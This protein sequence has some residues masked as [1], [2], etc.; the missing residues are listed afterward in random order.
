MKVIFNSRVGVLDI[1]TNEVCFDRIK[2]KSILYA[3]E[4]FRKKEIEAQ[5]VND[6]LLNL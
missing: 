4:Y 6:M 2:F 1:D 3:I 5:L